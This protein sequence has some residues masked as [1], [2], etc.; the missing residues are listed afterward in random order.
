MA[1]I[2]A[3]SLINYV[4]FKTAQEIPGKRQNY[5]EG[6]GIVSIR[7]LYHETMKPT[8]IW[9][10]QPLFL[11]LPSKMAGTENVNRRN[12][13]IIHKEPTSPSPLLQTTPNHAKLRNRHLRELHLSGHLDAM[14]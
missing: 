2:F 7:K 12:A 6:I 1:G 13:S 9:S 5:I 3:I 10:D 8:V 14:L 4:W 11:H